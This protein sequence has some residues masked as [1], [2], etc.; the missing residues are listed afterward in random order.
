MH[1]V[2]YMLNA[3]F[4]PN[5]L[6]SMLIDHSSKTILYR[7]IDAYIIDSTNASQRCHTHRGDNR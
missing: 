7:K 6:L 4:T 5:Y 2:F 3:K 1:S